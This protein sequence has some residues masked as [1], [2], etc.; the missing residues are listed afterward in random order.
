MKVKQHLS[1][2]VDVSEN[3]G[4]LKKNKSSILI[5]FSHDKPYILGG[6][7]GCP[8]LET[9]MLLLVAGWWWSI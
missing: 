7:P 5:G 8:F 1:V 3:R 9:P 2:D 4:V 6:Y